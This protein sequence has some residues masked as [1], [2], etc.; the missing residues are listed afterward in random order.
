M[1]KIK[2]LKYKKIVEICLWLIFIGVTYFLWEF[3]GYFE[4]AAY[5]SNNSLIQ[6][7]DDPTYSTILYS[8]NDEMAT[9]YLKDYN[10]RLINN[11][12]REEK[13]NVYLALSNNVNHEHIK[14]KTDKIA[15][16]NELFSYKD[17]NYAYYLLDTNMLQG[18]EKQYNFS[19]YN[20]LEGETFKPYELKIELEKI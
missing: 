9:K 2:T 6:I 20:D 3:D 17:E 7:L 12:Y 16:L 13:Y 4:T 10:L 5:Y 15:Y 1:K 18:S 14:I 19:L 11:T 8:L